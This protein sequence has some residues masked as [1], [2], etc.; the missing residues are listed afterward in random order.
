MPTAFTSQ[1]GAVI[2]QST[3]VNVTGCP[4]RKTTRAGTGKKKQKSTKK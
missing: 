2:H 3:P 4:K 1:D